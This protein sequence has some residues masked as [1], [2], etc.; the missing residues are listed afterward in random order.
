MPI[1]TVT[2]EV[3]CEVIVQVEYESGSTPDH[4]TIEAADIVKFRLV[5]GEIT[6][7][8]VAKFTYHD[9]DL[10]SRSEALV[11]GLLAKSLY[12]KVFDEITKDR[13]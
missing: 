4:D 5:E 7:G 2:L 11:L 13:D 3:Q 1:R 9:L 6:P 12:S 10:T 8:G